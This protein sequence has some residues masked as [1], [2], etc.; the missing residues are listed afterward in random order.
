MNLETLSRI[1][2]LSCSVLLL[3]SVIVFF[4]LL[5]GITAPYGKTIDIV[6]NRS[7]LE[8][9]E[10]NCVGRYSQAKGWG[11]LIPCKL[12]WFVM[13]SPNLWM[14]IIVYYLISTQKSMLPSSSE[15]P[16]EVKS[17]QSLPNLILIGLYFSHYVHRSIIY[18]LKMTGGNP[19]PL[20]VMLSACFFC[21]WNGFNLSTHLLILNQYDDSWLY[22]PRFLIGVALFIYGWTVNIQ[23][24]NILLKLRSEAIT[25]SDNE[26]KFKY[27]IPHGGMFEYVS[28]ANYCKFHGI[29][30]DISVLV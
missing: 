9:H 18:P 12:A 17:Y 22:D 7:M 3:S 26:V 5:F 15:P 1:N 27:K 11:A 6:E 10:C 20:T 21:A 23:S 8:I 29:S 24:D 28:C 25:P 16:I 2:Q 4:V 30:Y 19:M 13:E 14:S